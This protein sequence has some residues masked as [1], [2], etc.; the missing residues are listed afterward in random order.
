[1]D[2][3]IRRG[4]H[5]S[6]TSLPVGDEWTPVADVWSG[7]TRSD[8]PAFG[9]F[10]LDIAEAARGG[11][12]ELSFP[13]FH[14]PEISAPGVW[15]LWGDKRF[16]EEY[17]LSWNTLDPESPNY[18]LKQFERRLYV[19]RLAHWI[20]QLPTGGRILDLG[21]GIG[22]FAVHWLSE[23]KAVTLADPNDHALSLALGHLAAAGGRYDL[24]HVGAEALDGL[25]DDTFH[26]VSAMEVLC[27]LSDATPGIAEAARVLRRGGFLFCSVES[28][29]GSLDPM[30]SHSRAELDAALAQESRS[31]EGDTW[32][33]YFTRESLTAALE[34]AGLEVVTTFGTHYLPDGPL[35]RLVDFDRLGDLKYE[36]A[37]IEL[38]RM[39]EDSRRWE[40]A[41]RAWVAVARKP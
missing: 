41:A 1:M 12:L 21:G 26:A 15:N 6:G 27:Y 2:F 30:R 28:G 19:T 29:V 34:A 5:A 14:E 18:T 40:S 33:R 36:N 24:Q 7:C 9:E 38:E 39:L 17:P 4:K 20:A 35:H 10:L 8:D 37:L 11:E 13:P 31:V 32:V 23:G 25:A 22:R 16:A 3:R